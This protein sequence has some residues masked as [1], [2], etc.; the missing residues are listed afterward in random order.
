MTLHGARGATWLQW[1]PASPSHMHGGAL[2]QACT[3]TS[4]PPSP[5]LPR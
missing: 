3:S 1:E 5:P 4:P 2:T